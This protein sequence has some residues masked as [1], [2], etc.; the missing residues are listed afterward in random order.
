MITGYPFTRGHWQRAR[1]VSVALKVRVLLRSTHNL[2]NW[3]VPSLI[4]GKCMGPG[5]STSPPDVGI[6]SIEASTGVGVGI[7]IDKSDPPGHAVEDLIQ[8]NS[9]KPLFLRYPVQPNSSNP[10]FLLGYAIVWIS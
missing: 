7:L 8:P 1:V 2:L 9:S 10:L 6:K 4:R 3:P 5:S